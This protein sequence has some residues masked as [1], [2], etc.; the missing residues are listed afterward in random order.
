MQNKTKTKRSERSQFERK[1]ANVGIECNVCTGDII[2]HY[3]FITEGKSTEEVNRSHNYGFPFM[4]LWMRYCRSVHTVERWMQ[5]GRN[6]ILTATTTIISV[7]KMAFWDITWPPAALH[8][9]VNYV[10]RKK[11]S[12]LEL[13]LL[14][15]MQRC[16]TCR[17]QKETDEMC[18]RNSHTCWL[19]CLFSVHQRLSQTEHTK[20]NIYFFAFRSHFDYFS[21]VICVIIITIL[22]NYHFICH[23]LPFHLSLRT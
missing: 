7:D 4:S 13:E 14:R 12:E 5:R 18:T 20:L 15:Y 3:S 17:E 16:P 1:E 22:L 23:L 8:L 10:K 9:R 21:H 11:R 19:C 2:N 6:A